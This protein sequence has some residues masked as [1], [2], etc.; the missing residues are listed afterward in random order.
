MPAAK[1][2]AFAVATLV[3]GMA[4][5]LAFRKTDAGD[6][7]AAGSRRPET[8]VTRRLTDAPQPTTPFRLAPHVESGFHLP[9]AATG[10]GLAE[11]A[12]TPKGYEGTTSPIGALLQPLESEPTP[13]FPAAAMSDNNAAGQPVETE[14]ANRRHR[15]VDG[16]TLSKL[17]AEYLGSAERY[18]EIFEFNRDLLKSPDLLP[19]GKTLKIPPSLAPANVATPGAASP[20]DGWRPSK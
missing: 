5:A 17:A 20:F 18:L 12:R 13:I 14:T 7:V 15:I 8:L 2:I 11:I 1:K 10:A 6:A 9:T 3:T 4:A 19:V 16:D